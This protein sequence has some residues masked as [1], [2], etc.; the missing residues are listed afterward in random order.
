[1]SNTDPEELYLEEK[2]IDEEDTFL[3]KDI[4]RQ[5]K[6]IDALIDQ[7]RKEMKKA[8]EDK[9]EELKKVNTK[10][11]KLKSV[12]SFRSQKSLKSSNSYMGKNSVNK[13]HYLKRTE[14]SIENIRKLMNKIN[15][16]LI[17]ESVDNTLKQ[18]KERSHNVLRKVKTDDNNPE[19]EKN[20][21]A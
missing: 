21:F 17:A 3:S 10:D 11:T 12:K 6:E 13:N 16:D 4:K 20:A 2:R 8:K 18:I 19:E 15:H 7:K 5:Q 1:M 14:T 9:T